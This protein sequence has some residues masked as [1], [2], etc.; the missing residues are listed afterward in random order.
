MTDAP[1]DACGE[2]PVDQQGTLSRAARLR[3][4]FDGAYGA[5]TMERFLLS[6]YDQFAADS[7]VRRFQLAALAARA[8]EMADNG[9]DC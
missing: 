5:E 4:E 9:R 3:E 6:S 7:T 8:R 1:A 2:L